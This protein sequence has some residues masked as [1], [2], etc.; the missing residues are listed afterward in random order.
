MITRDALYAV[1]EDAIAGAS[2]GD[3]LEDAVSFRN[4]RES[5]D[6]D[7]KVVRFEC[8][9]GEFAMTTELKRR[10]LNVETTIQCWVTPDEN[11]E[12]S[13]DEAT[14]L[15][16]EMAWELFNVISTDPG[17]KGGVCDAFFKDY[18]TGYANMGSLR[19]GVTYLDGVINQGS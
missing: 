17:L 10:E 18:E 8:M 11:T 6:S 4:I 3:A 9:T 7:T 14:D 19:R 1:I 2:P 15:S 13:L 16:F 12:E 5:V